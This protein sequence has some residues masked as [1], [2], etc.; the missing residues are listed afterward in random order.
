M[1]SQW[2][3]PIMNGQIIQVAEKNPR[4]NQAVPEMTFKWWWASPQIILSSTTPHSQCAHHTAATCTNTPPPTTLLSYNHTAHKSP[5]WSVAQFPLSI[6]H[7]SWLLMTH[8]P[9]FGKTVHLLCGL[10]YCYPFLLLVGLESPHFSW[11][12]GKLA[13]RLHLPLSLAIC[14]HVTKLR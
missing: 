4:L 2:S 8:S 9:L 6:S 13:W 10:L 5:Q 3:D 1:K 11:L 12:H 7:F 14:D